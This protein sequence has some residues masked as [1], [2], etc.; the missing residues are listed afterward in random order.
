MARRRSRGKRLVVTLWPALAARLSFVPVLDGR[1]VTAWARDVLSWA[2]LRLLVDSP[3]WAWARPAAPWWREGGEGGAPVGALAGGERVLTLAVLGERFEP[4]ADPDGDGTALLVDVAPAR[5]EGAGVVL[6]RVV[7]RAS[8]LAPW[9]D[10][11][12]GPLN[13]G[14]PIGRAD[15]AGRAVAAAEVPAVR[16]PLTDAQRRALDAGRAPPFRPGPLVRPGVVPP[17]SGPSSASG[18]GV[19][20]PCGAV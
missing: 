5:E 20:I 8:D 2:A 4:E 11:R 15:R 12:E 19:D 3:G 10:R 1:P 6:R 7:V 18:S 13:A 16:R 9:R 14:G 17:D